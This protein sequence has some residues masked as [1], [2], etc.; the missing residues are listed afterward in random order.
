MDIVMVLVLNGFG[1]RFYQVVYEKIKQ[2]R[3]S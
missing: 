1:V 3:L 2:L